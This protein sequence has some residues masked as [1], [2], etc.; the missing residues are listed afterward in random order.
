MKAVNGIRWQ[1][2]PQ[3]QGQ[4]S[5][6]RGQLLTSVITVFFLFFTLTIFT[7]TR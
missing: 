2:V 7:G 6:P 3:I 5:G 1:A 4:L